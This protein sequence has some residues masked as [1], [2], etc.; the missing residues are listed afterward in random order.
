MVATRHSYSSARFDPS[1]TATLL[2]PRMHD[3]REHT[4]RGVGVV[5]LPSETAI[6]LTDRLR[7]ACSGSFPI[8]E[9]LDEFLRHAAEC[10]F[11]P[12]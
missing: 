2:R 11:I 4:R 1:L 9:L 3:G 7:D 6:M 10:E 5:A 8:Q 12:R